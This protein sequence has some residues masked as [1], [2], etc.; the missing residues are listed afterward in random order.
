MSTKRERS[1]V[2]APK[3]QSKQNTSGQGPTRDSSNAKKA[4]ENDSRSDVPRKDAN[5]ASKSR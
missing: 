2:D 1:N 5:K 3:G 4:R